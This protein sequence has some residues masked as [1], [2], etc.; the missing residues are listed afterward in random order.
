MSYQVKQRIR[1]KI[2]V[3]EAEGVWDKEKKQARQRRKY[4][5][6]LNEKTGEIDTPRKEKWSKRTQLTSGVVLAAG[7]CS[8]ENHLQETLRE[9]FGEE[10]EK[11][12]ALATYC[13][14]EDSPMYLYDNWAHSTEGMAPHAM[15]SQA[16]SGFLKR[17]GE[18]EASRDA[19]WRKW[20]N[21]HGKNRN[22]VFDITSIS[23][24]STNMVLDEFGHNRD[25]ES[26][27][28]INVGM[29]FADRPGRPLGYRVYPGSIGDVTTLKNLL[30]QMKSDY[31]LTH[32]RL[33]MDRG[34]YSTSNVKSLDETGYDFIMP[35]PLSLNSAKE[36]LRDT[37]RSFDEVANC[38]QFNDRPMG[39]ALRSVE[40]AG[41]FFE[42][43]VF[44]DL[45]RRTDETNTLLRKLSLVDQRLK[46]RSFETKEEAAAFIDSVASG[47]DR[48]YSIR[49][50]A[51][52]L[53]IGR[54]DAA[55][56]QHALKF[57]KII[58]IPSKAGADRLGLLEDYFRRDGVEKFFDTLKN[59]MDSSRGR[60][61]SQENFD[62]R[63]FV[64]MVGLIIYG[65]MLHRLKTNGGKLRMSF[66]EMVSH[67]KRLRRIHSADG[68]SVS[69]EMTRRQKDIFAAL[70]LTP[71]Q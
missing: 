8:G 27:P 26:L 4:L 65:E 70:G 71:E 47:M 56:N 16:V 44:L 54:D 17:L 50:T 28:Q 49:K 20:G 23:T 43:H 13:A 51:R 45:Q 22:L 25:G 35:L 67:L 5:G 9:S 42:A 10:G 59:E 52:Q 34:F 2:Y 14:T 32:S 66:P 68:S 39:H 46:E 61:H 53:R 38:F 63:L 37:D 21:L 15:S 55:I 36:L 6:V 62:G 12:F 48:L 41:R 31:S 33:V 29:L 1:G 24:Y 64:H 3:Y 11:I 7:K 69:S 18:D 60:V 19:F 40:L 57:G 30:R 58:I